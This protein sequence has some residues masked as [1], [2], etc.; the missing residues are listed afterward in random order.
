ML[1]AI[2]GPPRDQGASGLAPP[3][4]SAIA[5][6]SP[7]AGEPRAGKD[8]QMDI[9]TTVE[10]RLRRNPPQPPASGGRPAPSAATAFRARCEA[11]ALLCAVGELTLDESVDVL[12]RAA[13]A[14]GL[15]SDVGQDAVQSIMASA[16]RKVR[17]DV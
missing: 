4:K 3:F 11:R 14:N 7:E 12:Q 9:A 1:G 17:R 16:F 2:G 13:I 10:V 8:L 5:N 6:E 15:V